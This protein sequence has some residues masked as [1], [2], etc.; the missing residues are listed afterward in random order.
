MALTGVIGGGGISHRGIDQEDFAYGWYL[1]S[2]ITASDIG[3]AV[4]I[5]TSANYTLKLAGDSDIVYGR[6]STVEDR[7]VEGVLVGTAYTKGPM[8]FE[9]TGTVNV[10]E[11]VDGSDTTD[12]KVKAM[13]ADNFGLNYVVAVNTTAKTCVVHIR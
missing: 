7:G 6:L 12:G 10:G 13:T 8:Q 1:K 2:G 3:K 4:T 5:D 9:Y 11:A